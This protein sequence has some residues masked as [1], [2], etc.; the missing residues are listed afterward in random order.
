MLICGAKL[1]QL[2]YLTSISNK[3]EGEDDG[4]C[5]IV[6]F[7]LDFLNQNILAFEK[8][9]FVKKLKIGIQKFHKFL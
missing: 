2:T 8:K 7:R 4:P 5:F 9:F 3:G 6:H 1:V